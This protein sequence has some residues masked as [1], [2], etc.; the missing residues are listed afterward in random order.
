MDDKISSGES[1][2]IF[3]DFI[4]EKVKKDID[5]ILNS[6]N[7]EDNGDAQIM[8]LVARRE[9]TDSSSVEMFLNGVDQQMTML[10]DCVW[11]FK[12]YLLA[13]NVTTPGNSVWE[14][15]GCIE[16]DGG[17]TSLVGSLNETTIVNEQ[18]LSYAVSVD[19]ATDALKITVTGSGSDT[20]RW[21]AKVE[22]NQIFYGD[23]YSFGGSSGSSSS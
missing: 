16:N 8:T 18:L 13:V 19:D 10:S 2:G 3:N 11:A 15:K 22:I 12:I 21:L 9:T 1:E 5:K 14:I 20:I 7:F 17:S 6:G 4:K 23:G